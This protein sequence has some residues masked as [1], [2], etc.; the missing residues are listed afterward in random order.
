MPK[1][2][3]A[4]ADIQTA[5]IVQPKPQG[6]GM[7][8]C[9]HFYPSGQLILTDGFLMIVRRLQAAPA[10]GFSVPVRDLAGFKSESEVAISLSLSGQSI[11]LTGRSGLTRTLVCPEIIQPAFERLIS[12]DNA[13]CWR[14]VSAKYMT[15]IDKIAR[16]YGAGVVLRPNAK[17]NVNIYFSNPDLFGVVAPLSDPKDKNAVPVA[18]PAWIPQ[19]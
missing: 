6:A 2:T 18:V 15:A 17:G 16:L 19:P 14:A 4:K 10:N 1:I 13:D 3:L 12:R 9:A 11:T 5:L 8:E 7:H